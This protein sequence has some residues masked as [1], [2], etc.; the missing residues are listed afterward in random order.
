M[1][2]KSINIPYELLFNKKANYNKF[3]VFRCQVFF[4]IPKQFRRKLCYSALSE[5][6]YVMTQT[7]LLI[8]FMILLIIKI[9]FLV[10]WFFEDTYGNIS[11]TFSS[12]SLIN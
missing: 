4:M 9:L 10:Q 2:H 11:T 12:S 3:K 7:P 6:Y 5:Y 8:R 1:P